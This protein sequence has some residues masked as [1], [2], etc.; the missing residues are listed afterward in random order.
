MDSG[1]ERYLVELTVIWKD[2]PK[3]NLTV[4]DS[5]TQTGWYW[6]RHLVDLTGN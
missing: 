1:W 5:E 4:F 6:E 2:Y 3:E